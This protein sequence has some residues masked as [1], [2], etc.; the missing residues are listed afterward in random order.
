MARWRCLEV[1]CNPMLRGHN[2]EQ[3]KEQTGHRVA[4]WPVRSEAGKAKQ[5]ERNRLNPPPWGYGTRAGIAN[6]G[7]SGDELGQWVD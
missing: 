2:V 1:G 4:K 7:Q 5:R 3:H 6:G